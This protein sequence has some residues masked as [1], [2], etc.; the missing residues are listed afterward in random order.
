[1]VHSRSWWRSHL[2]RRTNLLLCWPQQVQYIISSACRVEK[3]KTV[4]VHDCIRDFTRRRCDLETVRVE[5]VWLPVKTGR[6][7]STDRR[8]S[9]TLVWLHQSVS[10]VDRVQH[11]RHHNIFLMQV[12]LFLCSLEVTFYG[13]K[14]T[15]LLTQ[16]KPPKLSFPPRSNYCNALLAAFLQVLL[17]KI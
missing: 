6:G 13:M 8:P 11:F 7:P 1:M 9:P 5:S 2:P 4:F 17:G 15:E 16:M 14:Y 10:M 12:H 3:K